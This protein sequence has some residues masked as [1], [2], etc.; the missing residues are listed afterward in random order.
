ME[1]ITI[2]LR[3]EYIEL[4]QLLKLAGACNSGGEGKDVGGRG[5]VKV[6]GAVELRKT[7]KV[8]AGETVTLEDLEI[9]VVAPDQ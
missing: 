5:I 4:N 8:R 6:N 3:G 2:Q 7:Y 9:K 1:Q